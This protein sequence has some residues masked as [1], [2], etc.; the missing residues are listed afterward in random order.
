MKRLITVITC[1]I[2]LLACSKANA[3]K[4]SDPTTTENPETTNPSTS[5]VGKPITLDKAEFL[6]KIVNYETT[7]NEWKYLGDKPAI[8]DFYASWCGPCKQIAP[9]LEE[10]ATEYKDSIYVYKVDVDKDKELGG[11]FGINSIPALIFIPMNGNPS[12]KV[13]LQGKAELTNTINSFLLEKTK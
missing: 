7:P 12:M 3:S 8:I 5:V 1:G 4:E 11:L 13:G 9:I 10:L 6:K 2:L